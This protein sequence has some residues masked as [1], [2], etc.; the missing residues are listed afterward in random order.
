MS[1]FRVSHPFICMLPSVHGESWAILP[2]CSVFFV[3]EKV[4]VEEERRRGCEHYY[5]R[6]P[7]NLKFREGGFP[8]LENEFTTLPGVL[9]NI[10]LGRNITWTLLVSLTFSSLIIPTDPKLFPILHFLY[11][12]NLSLLGWN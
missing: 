11:L 9:T 1:R 4:S 7:L 2:D 6:I 10:S 8:G 3:T 5:I 12:L